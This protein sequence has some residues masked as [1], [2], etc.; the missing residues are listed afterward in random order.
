M[1]NTMARGVNAEKKGSRK[2]IYDVEEASTTGGPRCYCGGRA[3][4]FLNRGFFFFPIIH[5]TP[6]LSSFHSLSKSS[7]AIP[8]HF[9]HSHSF[10][11]KFTKF[12]PF[13]SIPSSIFL[14]SSP[15]HP[16]SPSPFLLFHSRSTPFH[17]KF[18][19]FILKN[20]FSYFH[21]LLLPQFF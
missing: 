12:L 13:S 9:L 16:K 11:P 6:S 17:L 5:S 2:K 19:L 21:S 15:I 8:S 10:H 14:N 1:P 3:Q 4:Q 20:S 7:I 18:I